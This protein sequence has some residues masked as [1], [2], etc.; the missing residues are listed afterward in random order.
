MAVNEGVLLQVKDNGIGIDL[1]KHGKD[2]FKMYKRFNENY[3][4]RGLGLYLIK[5]QAEVL[6][7]YVEVQ[8]KP[9]EGTCFQVWLP[10]Y[11][12]AMVCTE[13][14]FFSSNSER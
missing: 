6:G 5:T 8:S 13:E 12:A 11:T 10:V 4:G 14:D 7:G 3:D 1:E 9:G 2:L